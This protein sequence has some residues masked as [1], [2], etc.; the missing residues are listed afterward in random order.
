MR[1][2]SHNGRHVTRYAELHS[3]IK[4][5]IYSESYFTYSHVFQI[6]WQLDGQ[7]LWNSLCGKVEGS[8]CDF[9]C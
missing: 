1:S 5:Y 7:S 4:Y 6:S 3:N 2:D 9:W 8:C